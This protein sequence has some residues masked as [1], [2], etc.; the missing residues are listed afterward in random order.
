MAGRPEIELTEEQLKTVDEMA[1]NQCKT[2]TIA[3]IIGID[4]NTLDKHY[5]T[6]LKKKRSEGKAALLKAQM[7]C[8]KDEKN[9]TMLIWLGKQHLNQTD[10]RDVTSGGQPIK[11]V[12]GIEMDDI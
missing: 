8:G 4:R 12:S 3:N 2:R 6:R 11:V 5:S 10:K 1:Y 7:E 9:P